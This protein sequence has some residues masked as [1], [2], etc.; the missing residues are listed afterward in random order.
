MFC[1]VGFSPTVQRLVEPSLYYRFVAGS[2][3]DMGRGHRVGEIRCW[4]DVV[5][6]IQ[7]RVSGPNQPGPLPFR[8]T[9]MTLDSLLFNAGTLFFAAWIAVITGVSV[10]AF[11][12][13]LFP[14]AVLSKQAHGPE[15]HDRAEPAKSDQLPSA[16]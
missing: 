4:P 14:S 6:A 3:G 12:P 16:R 15:S 5:P 10:A 9:T 2:H 11:G 8:G 7:G 1:T 13:D